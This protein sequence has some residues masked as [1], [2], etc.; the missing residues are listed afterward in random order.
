MAKEYT[1]YW[2]FQGKPLMEVP[3]DASGFVYLIIDKENG[4]KYIGKK[5]FW[6]KRKL[7]KTDKRRTTIESDWK[8]YY[9]SS[10]KIKA[11]IKENGVERFERHILAIGKLERYVNYLEVKYQFKFN[12]LEEPEMWYNDNINGC[13]YPHLYDDIDNQVSE[14][15]TILETALTQNSCKADQQSQL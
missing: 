9:S 4:M 10:D 12:I 7:K 1:N 2:M 6:S 3:K 11:L 5:S 15:R 8:H 13:W 14:D